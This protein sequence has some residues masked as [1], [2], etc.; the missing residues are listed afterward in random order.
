MATP[1]SN[2]HCHLL[3]KNIVIGLASEIERLAAQ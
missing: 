1:L 2:W 3:A